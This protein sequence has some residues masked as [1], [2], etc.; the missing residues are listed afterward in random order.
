MNRPGNSRCYSLS[1]TKPSLIFRKDFENNIFNF[2]K[3]WKR[4]KLKNEGTW[5]EKTCLKLKKKKI[6][7]EIIHQIFF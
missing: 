2:T 7:L 4:N 3:I 6:C 1:Q 5:N